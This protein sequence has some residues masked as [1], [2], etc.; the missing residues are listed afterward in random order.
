MIV[1]G[2]AG[3]GA[4]CGRCTSCGCG[5]E[6]GERGEKVLYVGGVGGVEGR[7]RFLFLE[8]G[9]VFHSE[10]DG[11]MDSCLDSVLFV[12]G[13]VVFDSVCVWAVE[14]GAEEVAE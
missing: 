2:G 4:G 9:T 6:G 12:F 1:V 14:E 13:S 3:C 7:G 5:V 10:F 8:N 11:E